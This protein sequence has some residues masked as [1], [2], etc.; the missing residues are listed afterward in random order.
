MS[1]SN[2]LRNKFESLL[3][4]DG[5]LRPSCPII[6]YAITLS[7]QSNGTTPSE[8]NFIM[9]SKITPATRASGVRLH[10]KELNI[11]LYVHK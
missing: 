2:K 5:I 1:V 8:I 3:I 11:L 10:L 7:S 6:V 4:N 9:P